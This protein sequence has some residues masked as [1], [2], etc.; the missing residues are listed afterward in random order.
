MPRIT[1]VKCAKERKNPDGSLKPNLVCELDETEIK[2]GDPYKWVRVKTGP[3]SSHK[4]VRCHTCPTWQRWDLSNSLSA[5]LEKVSHDLGVAVAEA[6]DGDDAT[7]A[8]DEAASAIR[9]LA[10]EKR[11]SASNVEEGFGHPT[12]QSEELAGIAEQLDS[13]AEEIEEVEIPDVP[14]PEEQDCEDCDATGEQ[15]GEQCDTCNGDGRTTPDEATDEQM[16]EWRSEVE[17]ALSI[18]DEGPV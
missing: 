8:R 15:D 16:D 13:W 11:E 2:P 6:G 12:E 4:R 7:S 14:E 17:D 3:R 10:Q 18:V 9:E 5:R 1:T